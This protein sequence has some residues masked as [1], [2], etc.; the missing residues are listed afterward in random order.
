MIH[1]WMISTLPRVQFGTLDANEL[2]AGMTHGATQV[3]WRD[4]D[5]RLHRG[6][7]I[8]LSSDE[9][10]RPI[11]LAWDWVEI[12][13]GVVAMVDPMTII[14]NLECSDDTDMFSAEDYKL[15]SLNQIVYQL[16]WQSRVCRSINSPQFGLISAHPLPRWMR[17]E[18]APL[19]APQAQELAIAA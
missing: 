6:S 5:P 19:H 9:Q 8:W 16:D 15:L 10:T 12:R 1:P 2:A 11:A 4:D 17:N 18:L 3:S 7:T 13:N 14:S